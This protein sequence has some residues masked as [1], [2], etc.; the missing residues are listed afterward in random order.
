MKNNQNFLENN[1][2][3]DEKLDDL[4]EK[5]KNYDEMLSNEGDMD[6]ES[7]FEI[8]NFI[9]SI[10]GGGNNQLNVNVKKLSEKAILPQYSRDGDA[11]MDLTA[12]DFAF[13]GDNLIS[14]NT[15]ISL[16]IP[17]GYVGLVFPRSSIKNYSL[18]LSNS[19]GVIDS[20]LIYL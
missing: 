5:L 7:F 20:K 12:T 3:D 4:I 11:G 16:E 15:G 6:N 1:D 13:D 14:Y 2:D 8:E 9:N 19:V 10:F 17:Y 18:S